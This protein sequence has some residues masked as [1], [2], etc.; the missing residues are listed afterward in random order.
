MLT[1]LVVGPHDHQLQYMQP[2]QLH[3]LVSSNPFCHL[4]WVLPRQIKHH[5]DLDPAQWKSQT[6]EIDSGHR[7]YAGSLCAHWTGPPVNFVIFDTL[8]SIRSTPEGYLGSSCFLQDDRWRRGA[9][10]PVSQRHEPYPRR[11]S[12]GYP[13]SETMPHQLKLESHFLTKAFARF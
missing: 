3:T 11:S 4:D 9:V 12:G 1:N 2:Y 10:L 13:S 8:R 5:Q 6:Q 7:L